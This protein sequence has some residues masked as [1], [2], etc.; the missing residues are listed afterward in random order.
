M[1]AGIDVWSLIDTAGPAALDR[2]PRPRVSTATRLRQV[3]APALEALPRERQD[4]LLSLALLW[5]DDHDGAHGLCQAHEGD[6]DCDYVHA[7]LHRREGD[8]ANAKYWFREVGPHPAFLVLAQV[9]A[10]QGQERL[11]D[12]GA[13]KPAAM[14]D[15]CAAALRGTASQRAALE[16]LQASEFQALGRHLTA[17]G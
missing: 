10:S 14:V 15:A 5:H 7:L 6:P 3:L 2:T 13:W 8:F 9:A 4:A 1:A 17:A 11:L 12:R 16:Q